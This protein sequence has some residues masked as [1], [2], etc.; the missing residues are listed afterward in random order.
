MPLRRRSLSLAASLLAAFS[1]A[2]MPL[3][4]DAVA[5]PGPQAATT[6]AAA[7]VTTHDLHFHG[8][9]ARSS[10]SAR[11]APYAWSGKR[12]RYTESIPSKWDWSLS[13]AV[14]K[15]NTSGGGIKF[16]RTTKP[17][18]ARLYIG[19]GNIGASAG[20]ATVGRVPHAWVRLSS[21]YSTVDSLDVYSRVE[22]MSI[23]S[24]E[25]G[26]VLGFEHTATRCSLMSPVLDVRGCGTV[27]EAEPG[28]YRCRTIDAPLVGRFVRTYGGRARYPAAVCPI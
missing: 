11:R 27:R 16:V 5:T 1:V 21:R 22:V 20:M 19:Y 4:V 15:W 13:T 17:R 10:G 12:I 18:K 9:T 2:L 8:D 3:G 7:A 6:R 23:F 26:H 28:Y 25:L 24:H 14:A